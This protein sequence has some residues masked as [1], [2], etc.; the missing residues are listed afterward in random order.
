[1]SM[2]KHTRKTFDE[3]YTANKKFKELVDEYSKVGRERPQ[4]E[5]RLKC[6]A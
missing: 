1:M 5:E 4:L 3:T 6:Y 2:C